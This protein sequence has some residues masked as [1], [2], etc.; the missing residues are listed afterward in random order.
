MAM[1]T[2]SARQPW[3]LDCAITDTTSAGLSASS[4]VRFKL[5]TLDHR[6]VRGVLGRL[7]AVDVRTIE[8]Q[9]QKL[10]GLTI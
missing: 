8:R 3:P 2:S 1:I 7:S 5:F 6:L 10:L 4:I 9:L